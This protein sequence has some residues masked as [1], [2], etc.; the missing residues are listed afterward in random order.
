VAFDLQKSYTLPIGVAVA[1][2]CAAAALTRMLPPSGT[3]V[4]APPSRA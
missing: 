4:Q 2:F 1:L 3:R